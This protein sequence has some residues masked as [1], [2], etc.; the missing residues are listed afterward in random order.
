VKNTARITR[1]RRAWDPL[2]LK[3]Q[4]DAASYWIER[5]GRE[6]AVDEMKKQF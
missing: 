1:G 2:R 5:A 3:L 4:P 6:R